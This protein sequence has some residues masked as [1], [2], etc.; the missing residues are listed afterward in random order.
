MSRQEKRTRI[1]VVPP[2]LQLRGQDALTGSY[3][4]NVRFSLDGR[5]GNYKVGYNDVQTV[6][7]GTRSNG[8]SWQD[9]M[10]G[11][12]TM[13]RLGPSAGASGSITFEAELS[14]SIKEGLFPYL[15]F[16]L[17]DDPSTNFKFIGVSQSFSHYGKAYN[18][19]I[20]KAIPTAGTTANIEFPYI[21]PNKSYDYR[22]NFSPYGIIYEPSSAITSVTPLLAQNMDTDKS[23]FEFADLIVPTP[24][25]IV[26]ESFTFAGWFYYNHDVSNVVNG[27]YLIAGPCRK[28]PWNIDNLDYVASVTENFTANALDFSI[29]FLSGSAANRMTLNTVAVPNLVDTWF[30]F[31][32]SFDGKTS[33]VPA[34]SDSIKVYINGERVAASSFSSFGAGFDS[35]DTDTAIQYGISS[36]YSFA[37]NSSVTGSVGEISFFNRELNSDEIKDIYYSQVPWNKKRRVIAGTSID[38][39]N[40]PYPVDAGEYMTTFNRDGMLVTGSIVKGVGDSSE[41]VHFS[42]GQEMQPFHDQQQFAADAKGAPVQNPFFATGSAETLVGEGFNS[43]L[44]SKNKIEIPIPVASNTV[45]KLPEG[46][47]GAGLEGSYDSPMAYYNFDKNVWEPIGIGIKI[48]S[49]DLTDCQDYLTV[50]FFD[51]YLMTQS[52]DTALGNL[53]INGL[54]TMGYCGS[55]FGFPYH[56]KY[57]ATSSQ[58]L[59]MSQYITEPFLLEKAVLNMG[60]YSFVVGTVDLTTITSVVTGSITTFFLLNQRRNQNINYFKRQAAFVNGVLTT[61]SVSAHVPADTVLTYDDALASPPITT[62]V[63]TLR[64]ILGFSQ[65]YSFAKDVLNTVVKRGAFS[66]VSAVTSSI[67]DLIP[68]TSN[69]ILIETKNAGISGANYNITPTFS[70][71]MGTPPG[72][73]NDFQN[74]GLTN[75]MTKYIPGSPAVFDTIYISFDGSRTGINVTQLSTRGLNNDLFHSEDI[76]NSLVPGPEWPKDKWKQNPYILYPQDK[77]ILGCQAPVSIAPAFRTIYDIALGATNAECVLTLLASSNF[78]VEPKLILY[79]SYIRE[80]REYNDGTNQLLSSETIHEVIE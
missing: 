14:G 8:T 62:R 53:N 67:N 26:Y 65:V 52:I 76:D 55:D 80:N 25:K 40:D 10:I 79:G 20:D 23:L 18:V 57:H 68:V 64:D 43:P 48:N 69:D 71:S 59:D 31:A 73:F 6:V 5:S 1:R 39:D 9:S 41:W 56:P 17:A 60:P 4:T 21:Q 63:D 44:W 19:D 37:K 72:L 32:F 75:L 24:G 2:K 7:F 46:K 45:L 58:T 50:G 22:P 15:D 34:T 35:Y 27:M 11:Y 33:G 74:I 61:V 36:G 13:Q 28:S 49:S 29:S 30:H 54:H 16:N 70:M 66:I 47:I 77:L 12:W 38:L 51:G 3:P 42:P 78:L